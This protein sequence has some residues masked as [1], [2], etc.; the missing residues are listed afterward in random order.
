M[1]I[2]DLT[3]IN[4]VVLLFVLVISGNYIGEL[5]PCRVQYQ[6]E[7]NIYLKHLM[8]VLTLSFFVILTSSNYKN[9]SNIGKLL[10]SFV[11]YIFF[12]AF[13]KTHYSVWFSLIML[14]TIIYVIS[15]IKEDLEN[16]KYKIFKNMPLEKQITL[17]NKINN[18]LSIISLIVVTFG[19]II[20]YT[21]KQREYK[22][23]FSFIKFF[24]GKITCKHNR[25]NK[26]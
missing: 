15:L 18:I 8:G 20:Y 21:E 25:T 4:V 13:A 3:N 19:V 16:K 6:L 23:K 17:L 5:L 2:Q 14:I 9:F 22:N 10:I 26:V 11:L 1:I 7:H 24:T 12:L